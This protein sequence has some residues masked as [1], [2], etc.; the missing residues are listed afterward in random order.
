MVVITKYGFYTKPYISTIPLGF[1]FIVFTDGEK[2]QIIDTIESKKG[3]EGA[4][5]YIVYFTDDVTKAPIITQLPVSNLDKQFRILNETIDSKI[6]T[7]HQIPRILANIGTAGSLGD[8]KEMLIAEQNFHK[9]YTRYQQQI[10][11]D[12]FYEVNLVNGQDEEVSIKLNNEIS[13][14]MI[15]MYK[16]YLTK[17][18]VREFLGLKNETP[19]Q[20]NIL[21]NV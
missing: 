19:T 18:E 1:I 16:D 2:R 12:F 6:I 5:H 7:S 11:T 21:D 14:T 9:N 4:G 13:H 15:E 8:G 17:E 10:L 20:N 3:S